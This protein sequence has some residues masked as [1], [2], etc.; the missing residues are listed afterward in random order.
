M[1]GI[2]SGAFAL[3]L[4]L[5]VPILPCAGCTTGV[6]VAS[7][8]NTGNVNIDDAGSQLFVNIPKATDLTNDGPDANTTYDGTTTMVEVAACNAHGQYVVGEY[9]EYDRDGVARQI[10]A[11]N[12][13][14]SAS[15]ITFTPALSAA[16]QRFK[17]IRL[18]GTNGSNFTI[19]ARLKAP[20]T[21]ATCNAVYGGL[22]LSSFFTTDYTGST[23]TAS[24][25]TSGVCSGNVTN[26]GAAG[27]SLG[28]YER[29]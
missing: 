11:V 24:L 19:D 4:L 12:C 16:S 15:V 23:R 25:P 10:T 6:D 29:D 5:P 14:A 28:A 13:T 21:T 22:N 9:I 2:I 7:T 8:A 27:W 20:T 3:I 26:A 18:W 17:S 1:T